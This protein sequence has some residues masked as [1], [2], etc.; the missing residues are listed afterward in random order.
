MENNN[1][2][3]SERGY[4]FDIPHKI[5]SI[6]DFQSVLPNIREKD[7]VFCKVDFLHILS[8]ALPYIN[9]KFYLV[10]GRGDYT[11][12]YCFY[13]PEAQLVCNEILNSKNIIK[14]YAVNCVDHHE[15]FVPIPLGIDYHTMNTPE[16]KMYE[17]KQ[18]TPHDQET[19]LISIK[20]NLRPLDKTIPKAISNFH[21]SMNEPMLRKH[22]RTIA[23][24]A[25]KDKNCIVWLPKQIRDD[26]WKSCD[27]YA[28]VICPFGNGPD[29]HRTYETLALGRVPIIQECYFNHNLF[30]GLPVVIV[31]EWDEIT[32]EFLQ[33]QFEKILKNI[34]LG[35]YNDERMT[36]K[37]W[38]DLITNR[39]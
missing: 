38:K 28:F 22:Y 30:K 18:L 27:E 25:L 23:Y 1:Y 9:S 15:K 21:N 8:Q 13:I 6:Q 4:E 24:D 3:V 14:W 2:F 5:L 37:F 11:V 39:E 36:T 10:S 20:N 35:V 32:E 16:Y 33:E 12:P 34:E 29:T 19:I 7:L 31:K 17:N 26:F